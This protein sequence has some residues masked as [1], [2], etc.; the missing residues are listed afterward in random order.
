MAA[1]VNINGLV[2]NEVIEANLERFREAD[3]RREDFLIVSTPVLYLLFYYLAFTPNDCRA[4][5]SQEST[6]ETS[7][8]VAARC[9]PIVTPIR[10]PTDCPL[11]LGF[12]H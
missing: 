7:G 3:K 8:P 9:L 10:F 11:V 6:M 5:S 12:S 1:S 2:P 4:Q